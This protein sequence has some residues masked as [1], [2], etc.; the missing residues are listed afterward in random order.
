MSSFLDIKGRRRTKSLIKNKVD[1]DKKCR[2]NIQKTVKDFFK[3]HWFYDFVVEEM[4][5]V[6]TKLK[7]DLYNHTKKI[8]VEVQGQQHD[9][10]VAHFHGTRTGFAKQLD[11]DAIKADWCDMNGIN[12]VYI[13]SEDLPHLS[14]EWFLE[15]YNVRI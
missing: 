4:T 3:E 12:M 7:I 11:R 8:A 5:V 6:G 2:S 9:V 10:F 13:R 1:W 15:K 14:P